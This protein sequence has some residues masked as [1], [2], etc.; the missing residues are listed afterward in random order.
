LTKRHRGLPSAFLR[1]DGIEGGSLLVHMFTAAFR[2]LDLALF[3]FRKG[4][5]HFEGFLASFTIEFVARHGD[6]L[7]KEGAIGLYLGLYAQVKAVSR[8]VCETHHG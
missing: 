1:G 2:A 4:K 6:L 5:N 8:R 3:I 7:R